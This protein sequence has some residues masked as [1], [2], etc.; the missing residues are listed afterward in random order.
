MEIELP[1]A[2]RGL[3]HEVFLWRLR[4]IFAAV[5]IGF[6]CG[7]LAAQSGHHRSKTR[8]NKAHRKARLDVSKINN[9]DTRDPVGPH[10]EGEAVVRAAILL[11][12]LR[13]SPGEI[14]SSY[15]NNL[16]KAIAAF[17][18]VTGLPGL[19]IVDAPTWAA[20]NSDQ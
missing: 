19:G 14:S 11:G 15:N 4:S 7:S 5:L 18:S 16:A 9:P 2:T 8:E 17:Q 20:L 10:S 3:S 1:T 13:F 6:S 12:R